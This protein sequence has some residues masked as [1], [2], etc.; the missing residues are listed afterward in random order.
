MFK[1]L[2]L[3]YTFSS[4]AM[5]NIL[6]CVL[7]GS[8]D[9]SIASERFSQMSRLD[10]DGEAN[11]THRSHEQASLSQHHFGVMS[12]I[13]EDASS[14]CSLS[15]HSLSL[16]S[17]YHLT[18]VHDEEHSSGLENHDEWQKEREEPIDT[19]SNRTGNAC[20]LNNSVPVCSFQ[21]LLE[22]DLGVASSST[23]PSSSGT[24]LSQPDAVL[25]STDTAEI[26]IKHITLDQK[27]DPTCTST[28]KSHLRSFESREKPQSGSSSMLSQRT[29]ADTTSMSV[30]SRLSAISNITV[31]SRS[32]QTDDTIDLS[33]RQLQLH[34]DSALPAPEGGKQPE[35]KN[36]PIGQNITP[37]SEGGVYMAGPQR[38][39]WSSGSHQATD[40][41]FLTSQPVFQSTPAVLLG[42]GAPA[43]GKLSPV[44]SHQDTVA[45]S[46]QNSSPKPAD[47]P[48][49]TLSTT[50]HQSIAGI[51]LATSLHPPEAQRES[52]V[53]HSQEASS[54]RLDVPIVSCD[55]TPLNKPAL[56]T[57]LPTSDQQLKDRELTLSA[58]RVHCLPS[59]SYVQKVDA[60]KAN[61]STSS[62]FYDSL[63][64]QGFN[65]VSLKRKEQ[66]S[67]SEAIQQQS[68]HYPNKT[69]SV[70]SANNSTPPT[71]TGSGVPS[72]AD[73]EEAGRAVGCTSPSPFTHSHSQ[74]SLGT[75]ITPIQQEE[76]HQN[77]HVCTDTI[78]PGF[79]T[80]AAESSPSGTSNQ[81]P[82]DGSE[83]GPLKA[84]TLLIVDHYSLNTNMVSSFPGGCHVEERF[85]ASLGASSVVSLEVDNYAP[86]W[87]SRPGSPPRTT[88][89]NIE[90]RIPVSKS[91]LK[92]LN[93]LRKILF[94]I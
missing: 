44:Y 63:S 85:Q 7:R 30:S 55:D 15:Q 92:F 45:V 3:V 75:V 32:K 71:Q 77:P 59:L 13:L 47:I 27:Q 41:S 80:T 48:A 25:G 9:L 69:S 28:K 52:H 90:D 36:T 74:S 84:P 29:S 61:Q 68:Q 17:N 67:L 64:L 38:T 6:C 5:L 31:R 54:S 91:K 49:L 50:S 79:N 11:L 83:T 8:P 22:T 81:R 94:I 93:I 12:A 62:S 24:V 57:L 51:T 18:Q 14:C 33:F 23:V 88:E 78:L 26:Q 10:V 56:A 21:K 87:T 73:V 46:T 1:K 72:C 89:F 43:P 20:G 4:E 76:L 58:G 37:A 40:G 65:G 60:W 35:N 66:D 39:L 19:D 70:Y 82:A 34:T 2:S 16:S 86:Y 53:Q 42:R